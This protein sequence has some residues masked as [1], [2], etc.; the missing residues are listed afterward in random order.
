MNDDPMY[1]PPLPLK[2]LTLGLITAFIGAPIIAALRSG[3][4]GNLI[5][6][7]GAGFALVGFIICS[8][9]LQRLV[10]W[11]IFTFYWYIAAIGGGLL[12]LLGLIY[13][14][15]ITPMPPLPDTMNISPVA[16][17]LIVAGAMIGIV[18]LYFV[19]RPKRKVKAVQLKSPPAA[20]PPSPPK[21]KQILDTAQ[22][23]ASQK[24]DYDFEE[25]I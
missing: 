19:F 5:A 24:N 7:T 9:F 6:L 17:G 1:V 21:Q 2:I 4:P 20:T 10:L 22:Q 16:N 11:F 13:I 18:V 14:S 3:S 12:F 23:I 8:L 25:D 15:N